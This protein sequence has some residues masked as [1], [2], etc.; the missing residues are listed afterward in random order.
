MTDPTSHQGSTR[1]RA[2]LGRGSVVAAVLTVQLVAFTLLYAVGRPTLYLVVALGSAGLLGWRAR[3]GW[4][5]VA[6][7]A[8]GTVLLLALGMPLVLFFVKL[9]PD[10]VVEQAR[11]PEVHRMLYLTV[12][13]PLLAALAALAFGTP[14]A[15]LLSRGFVGQSLVESLVDLP[16][17]VPHSV[18]G[19]LVLFGFGRRGL[20]PNATIL[21]TTLGMVLALTF[22]SAPYAVNAVRE[23]FET[24]DD[25]L[26]LAARSHG[27]SAF[28]S[29]R[30]VHAPLAARGILT[31]GLLAWARSVSEF[32]AV[33]IVAYSV[34]FFYPIA[35]REV[36]S[37]HAPV[38]IYN[39]FTGGSLEQ[40]GAVSFILLVMTGLVFFL[41]R[42]LAYDEVELA[43]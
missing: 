24:V 16:L 41:I 4:F 7:A 10:L 14:L 42:S 32:G 23:A 29:F 39:T 1:A 19:I 25:R 3:Q 35:G 28:E 21:T 8:M 9:R 5:G 26:E 12:Y 2:A 22:V 20:F 37:Q 6:T 43:P 33:A 11:S 38:F 27:A 15:F 36:V 13:G 31:G 30:R 17:V 40:A 34:H 18:A